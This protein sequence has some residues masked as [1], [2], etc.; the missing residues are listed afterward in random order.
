MENV[1]IDGG[2]ANRQLLPSSKDKIYQLQV[3]GAN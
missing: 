1:E 3:H 2:G